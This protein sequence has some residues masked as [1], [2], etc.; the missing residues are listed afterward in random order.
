MLSSCTGFLHHHSVTPWL[1]SLPRRPAF[2]LW[3]LLH[4]LLLDL[5]LSWLLLSHSRVLPYCLL[6]GTALQCALH[7]LLAHLPKYHQLL[8]QVFLVDLLFAVT[9]VSVLATSRLS[10]ASFRGLSKLDSSSCALLAPQLPS[11]HQ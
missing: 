5:M 8:R 6:L 11:Q 1:S 2:A 7:L 9:T 10:A 3:E 4:L